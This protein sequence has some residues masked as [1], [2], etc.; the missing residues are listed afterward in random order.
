MDYKYYTLLAG[1]LT[2][3]VTNFISLKKGEPSKFSTATRIGRIVILLAI[4]LSIFGIWQT[5]KDDQKSSD[6]EKRDLVRHVADSILLANRWEFDT[7]RLKQILDSAG[8]TINNGFISLRK[9]NEN[10]TLSSAILDRS[11]EQ[12]KT[13]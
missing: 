11:H 13:R 7:L 9:L 12:Q 2:L 8:V 3:A 5:S 1:L 6:R 4:G 10:L